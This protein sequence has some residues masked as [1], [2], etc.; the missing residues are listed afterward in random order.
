LKLRF[1]KKETPLWKAAKLQGFTSRA[2]TQGEKKQVKKGSFETET[3]KT[4][5]TKE[6]NRFF[7]TAF[8]RAGYENKKHKA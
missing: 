2:G 8:T 6:K 5:K 3:T 4:T 1:T 7:S